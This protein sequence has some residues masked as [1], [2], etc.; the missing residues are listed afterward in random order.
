MNSRYLIIKRYKGTKSQLPVAYYHIIVLCIWLYSGVIAGLPF[1]GVGDYV[2]E[3][4]L[5]TCSFDYLSDDLTT[6]MFIFAFFVVAWVFPVSI[7]IGSYSSVLRYIWAVKLR[8]SDQ[9][10]QESRTKS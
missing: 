5:T 2:P 10:H 1:F 3:G 4:Y 8:I 7:I 9:G 6:R